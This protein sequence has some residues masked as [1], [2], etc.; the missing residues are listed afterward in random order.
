MRIVIVI[1]RRNYEDVPKLSRCDVY[2][3]LVLVFNANDD[4]YAG[5]TCD[6]R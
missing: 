2:T 1:E 5:Y 3:Y 4:S 6:K